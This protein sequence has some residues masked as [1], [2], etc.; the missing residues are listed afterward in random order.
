M[1][2]LK[3]LKAAITLAGLLAITI[4]SAPADTFG[5]TGNEFTIDF[6]NIGNAGNADDAGAGGGIYSSPY[7]GVSYSYRMGTYEISQDAI[8]KATASGLLN[9]TAGPHTGNEPAADMTWYEAA[10]F[11]NWLNTSTGHQA[12]YDL[13]YSGGWSMNLWSSGNAWQLDGENLYRHK[14]AY[15]FLPSEDEWYKAAYHQND[16]VTANYWDYATGSNTIPT[17]ALTDGTL[18]GSAVFNGSEAGVPADPA[19]VN[20]AGG[21][22]AYGTMGQNGNVWEWQESAF[23]GIN[24]T[25]SEGRAVRGGYWFGVGVYL[26]SSD[27][28]DATA[29]ELLGNNFGFRIASVPEPSSAVLLLGGGLMWLLKRRRRIPLS[30]L[31]LAFALSAHS[32]AGDSDVSEVSINKG[33]TWTQTSTAD[34]VAAY[35]Y[36]TV[37]VDDSSSGAARITS[38]SF[39]PPAGSPIAMSDFGAGDGG[40]H[41]F[42][43]LASQSAFDSA[44][45]SGSYSFS[46]QTVNAPVTYSPSISSGTSYPSA[47]PKILNLDW[48]AGALRIDPSQAYTFT[49]NSSGGASVVFSIDGLGPFFLDASATSF[50]LPAGSL[51]PNQLTGAGVQF[52]NYTGV[53]DA[54]TWLNAQYTQDVQFNIQTVPEPSVSLLLASGAFAALRRRRSRAAG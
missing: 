51:L 19:D 16:G 6:V 34:P 20:L 40:F 12:A 32:W 44:Y 49:W 3:K 25:S 8:D 45:P 15:Y 28:Y 35:F 13:T 29:P 4:T 17:Q 9:V 36:L 37:G 52:Y 42:D 39:T 26:R 21:L 7:G 31:A 54:G 43:T 24:N 27:R 5:T 41:F 50:L 10:A 11:V 48:S 23:D 33:H 47:I 1:H 14:D 2:A 22:S 18:A 46:I 30:M 53:D 38:A